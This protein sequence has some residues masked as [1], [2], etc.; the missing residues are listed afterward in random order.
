MFHHARIKCLEKDKMAQCMGTTPVE[1]QKHTP[2][3]GQQTL[4]LSFFFLSWQ[5][6]PRA[7]KALSQKGMHSCLRNYSEYTH[8]HTFTL[9]GDNVKRNEG[10]LG[11]CMIT[12]EVRQM[13][14]SFVLKERIEQ[15][16]KCLIFNY[17]LSGCIPPQCTVDSH[18]VALWQPALKQKSLAGKVWSSKGNRITPDLLQTPH[19][20]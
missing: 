8:T 17:L 4:N 12:V 2:A 1:M 5:Q 6:Y 14:K 3:W 13:H 19:A 16:W 20:T 7:N 9:D 18:A 11:N 15:K 10:K